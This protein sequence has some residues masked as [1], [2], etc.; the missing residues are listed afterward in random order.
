MEHIEDKG[1]EC[2]IPAGHA[3]EDPPA[4]EAAP[5]EDRG[6]TRPTSSFARKDQARIHVT[7]NA[8]L[9][10]FPL[11]ALA[12]LGENIRQLRRLEAKFRA[13]LK[14]SSAVSNMLFDR[15]WS[16]YLRCVLAARAEAMALAPREQEKDLTASTPTLSEKEL[17]TL[18]WAD[19]DAERKFSSELFN[20][21]ALLQRY[22][23]HFSREMYRALGML[24]VLR[25]SGEAGLERCVSK[26]L[27]L[28]NDRTGG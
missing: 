15:M 5:A 12:T 4:V 20:Q 27:G 22:D 13:E 9:S 18:V 11:Q 10:R 8:I 17:P 28:G 19:Q 3:Q 7:R 21:L 14:P 1:A 6:T 16:S 2:A 23:T 25:D 24:L 26:A